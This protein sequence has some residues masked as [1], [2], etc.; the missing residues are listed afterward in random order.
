[1]IKVSRSRSSSKLKKLPVK[2]KKTRVTFIHTYI[3]TV[4]GT[5]PARYGYRIVHKLG[6]GMFEG[7]KKKVHSISFYRKEKK[8]EGNNDITVYLCLGLRPNACVLR[9]FFFFCG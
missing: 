6:D 3:H 7:T 9:F 1:M 8:K 4:S 2:T 5:L